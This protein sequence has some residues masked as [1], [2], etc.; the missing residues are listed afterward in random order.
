MRTK[1]LTGFFI[2]LGLIAMI[3]SRI[4]T[5]Y[6]FD[7][8][9]IAISC[10]ACFE[11]AVCLSKKEKGVFKW[12]SLGYPILLYAVFLIPFLLKLSWWW[13]LIFQAWLLVLTFVV[14]S[15]ICLIKKQSLSKVWWTVF[16]IIYPAYL[17]AFFY[18]VNHG[19]VLL[20]TGSV[21]VGLLGIVLVLAIST[22]TDSAAMYVGMLIKGP[23]I[24]EKAS[25]NKTI[26]G[27]IG[28][29]VFGVLTA[30]CIYWIFNAFSNFNFLF[31][32][33]GIKLWHFVLI[34]LIGSC[35]NQLGDLLESFF[36]RKVGV[37]DTGNFFPG[38]GG[39]MDRVDGWCFNVVGI[40]FSLLIL[41]I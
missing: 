2:F 33:Y 36:K 4:I 41:F 13:L 19:S 14:L 5:P 29:A 1:V 20:A 31:A 37:K 21:D 23:K 38:H 18:F 9:F 35:L 28:G 30:M 39:F 16:S 25:P 34:G 7:A 27:C 22:I 12:V 10:M 40:Y 26:S 24:W 3:S 11:I 15:I 8:C 32:S 17:L 6:V